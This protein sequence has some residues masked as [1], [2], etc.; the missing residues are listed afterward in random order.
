MSA[1][2]LVCVC[3]QGSVEYAQLAPEQPDTSPYRPGARHLQDLLGP[4]GEEAHIPL[5]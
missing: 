1:L 3:Q 2:P 5:L 4:A